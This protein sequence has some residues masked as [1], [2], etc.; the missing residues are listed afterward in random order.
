MA[1]VSNGFCFYPSP[2]HYEELYNCCCMGVN[3]D[4]V[5][6]NL[7]NTFD[8]KPLRED[9]EN[10]I[11][12]TWQEELLQCPLLYNGTKFRLKDLALKDGN[13]ILNVGIT[14]YRDFICTNMCEELRE[15]I[16]SW[17][18]K[19]YDDPHA[20]FAD[21]IGA[22]GLVISR[23]DEAVFIRRSQEVYEFAG[24]FHTPGGH[25]EPNVSD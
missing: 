3:M 5:V 15:T 10:K 16:R 18:T 21:P 6:V 2:H 1:S 12:Q 25:P 8:R 19:M 13:L 22:N 23:D 24:R 14:C 9:L 4:K 17:G 20:C 7:S 11:E